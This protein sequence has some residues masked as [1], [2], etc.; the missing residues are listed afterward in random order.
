MMVFAR[1]NSAIDGFMGISLGKETDGQSILTRGRRRESFQKFRDQSRGFDIIHG[2]TWYAF[3]YA[4]LAYRL[5]PFSDLCVHRHQYSRSGGSSIAV[6]VVAAL[7][8][9][10]PAYPFMRWGCEI[11]VITTPSPGSLIRSIFVVKATCDKIY[12]E[13]YNSKD[14][15]LNLLFILSL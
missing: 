8:S 1:E 4:I 12:F 11:F 10:I 6:L 3:Y 13:G 14:D 5:E 2:H 15:K 7:F 9:R